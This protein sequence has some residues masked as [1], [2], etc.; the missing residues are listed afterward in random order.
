MVWEGPRLKKS[1]SHIFYHKTHFI[2][3]MDSSHQAGS[4]FSFKRVLTPKFDQVMTLFA[5]LCFGDP[6]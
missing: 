2:A 4:S 3:F 5:K 1:G 6:K